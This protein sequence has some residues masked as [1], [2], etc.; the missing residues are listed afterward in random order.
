[1]K[2]NRNLRVILMTILMLVLST[3]VVFASE[4]DAATVNA[5][6]YG[7]LTLIPP[8]IAIILA[9][10]TKNVV[11]SLFVGAL[12]GCFLIQLT[13]YNFFGALVQSF[14]DF[15]SRA[16]NSLADPWNAGIVLQVLVIGGVIHL[17]A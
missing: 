17:V 5:N 14:L 9:F 6:H 13:N 1:M 8:V 12:S 11:I 2:I 7:I 4:V 10:L 16:L 15:I 3:T